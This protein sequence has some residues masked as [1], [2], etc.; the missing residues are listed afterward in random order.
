MRCPTWWWPSS[1]DRIPGK[2]CNSAANGCKPIVGATAQSYTLT[3]SDVGSTIRV[4]ETA[5]NGT[6]L[7][8][9]AV[10]AATATVKASAGHGRPTAK[11]LSARIN[12][13]KHTATFHLGSVGKATGFRCALVR[14]ATR[15]GAKTP[16][17]RYSKCRS[18]KTFKHL[19]PGSYVLRVRA[20]GPG[21]VD[22]TPAT[23]RFRIK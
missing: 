23:Y 18:P 14:R 19:K 12:S 3:S 21:G 1:S 15:K 20:V 17:P 6:G 13:K 2:R 16:A 11:V 7:G 4:T 22:K 10:S 5:G 9:P 8:A